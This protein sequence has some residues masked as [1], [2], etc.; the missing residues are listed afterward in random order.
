MFHYN[1]IFDHRCNLIVIP[2][3][4]L[5]GGS[6]STTQKID[7][8]GISTKHYKK[9]DGNFFLPKKCKKNTPESPP[10]NFKKTGKI[11]K[12]KSFTEIAAIT[13]IFG[14]CRWYGYQIVQKSIYFLYYKLFFL[15]GV[16]IG[17]K[18]VK[19]QNLTSILHF[20]QFRPIFTIF[21]PP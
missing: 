4:V 8:P 5:R 7:F 2:D 13:S 20:F 14:V 10:L 16:N 17:L 1:Y 11:G 12:K 21:V 3:G 15:W 18:L 6:H 19:T 9:I